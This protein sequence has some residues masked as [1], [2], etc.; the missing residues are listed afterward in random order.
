MPRF[1]RTTGL[2][3][4]ILAALGL[5]LG[6]LL[7]Y[8]NHHPHQALAA[9]PFLFEPGNIAYS[10]V[11][12]HGFGSPFRVDTGPTAWMTPVWPM[13]LA[14][15]FRFFG[16]YTFPAFVAAAVMNVFFS[17]LVCVPLFFVGKR[18]GGPAAAWLWAISPTAIVLPYESLW[19]GSLAALFSATIIWATLR[20]LNWWAYG[21]LWG[22]ALMTSATFALLFPFIFG[23]MGWRH[24][25]RKPTMAAAIALLCCV[26]W[27]VR[28]YVVFHTFVPLR[29]VAGLSLW[30]GNVTPNRHPISNSGERAKYIEQGEIAYM[31]DKRNEAVQVMVAHPGAALRGIATRFVEVWTGGTPTPFSDLA[32]TE[33]LWFR[34]AVLFSMGTAVLGAAGIVLLFRGRDPAVFPL[35]VFPLIFPL[36]YY[37]TLVL[38]RYRL[39]LDPVLFLLAAVALQ[40]IWHTINR[41]SGATPESLFK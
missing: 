17:V 21:L 20:K 25:P 19:E 23:W 40:V 37:V 36:P 15:I 12:G 30:I 29:S 34:W 39:P 1:V 11:N 8:V 5:R 24:G 2:V 16:S 9:I 22:F 14:G 33:S 13:L 28:N 27:T 38:P 3:C 7:N 31:R 32:R 10:L 41:R 4:L 6:F 26:P 18:V 35:A